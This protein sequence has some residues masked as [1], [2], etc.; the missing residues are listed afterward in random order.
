MLRV[1]YFD[2]AQILAVETASTSLPTVAAAAL[3]V[4]AAAA[5]AAPAT[6]AN[7]MAAQQRSVKAASCLTFRSRHRISA[8]AL[9]RCDSGG[10]TAGGKNALARAGTAST[11]RREGATWREVCC[12]LQLRDCLDAFEAACR[13]CEREHGLRFVAASWGEVW[14]TVT[15]ASCSVPCRACCKSLSAPYDA[16]FSRSRWEK[17]VTALFVLPPASSLHSALCAAHTWD[18]L[19]D[20]IQNVSCS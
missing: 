6:A 12:T 1:G 14:Q 2:W 8:R 4:A 19:T 7:A 11:L 17:V 3:A 13:E 15:W 20:I 16:W 9:C 18:A 10:R 5:A